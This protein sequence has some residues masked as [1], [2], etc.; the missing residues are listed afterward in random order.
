MINSVCGMRST[1]R[2]CTDMAVA[3]EAQGHEVKIAYGRESVPAQ[4]K[5]F[6]IRIGN[7]VA[8]KMHGVLSRIFDADG[9]GS[10]LA[11]RQFI[12]WVEEYDPDVV[13]L[14]NIHGYYINHKILFDYLKK[15]FQPIVNIVPLEKP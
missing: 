4:Y 10:I 14:H 7:D 12:A 1:G 9:R 11:T 8:V 6:S 3:L 15:I 2:I 5:R 13:H